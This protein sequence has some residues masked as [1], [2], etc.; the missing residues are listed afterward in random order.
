MKKTDG[1]KIQE[2]EERRQEPLTTPTALSAEATRDI[3]GALNAIPTSSPRTCWPSRARTTRRSRGD[4][5]RP[6]TSTTITATSPPR[7]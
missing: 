2:L 7:A 3:A 1:A 4:C 6:M 5:A